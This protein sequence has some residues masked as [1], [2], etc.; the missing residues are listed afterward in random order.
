MKKV[1]TVLFVIALLSGCSSSNHYSY[2]SEGDTV[3]FSGPNN[4]TYTKNDLYKSL[5]VAAKDAI[6]SD[7][8]DNIALELDG[9]DLEA[10]E[11]DADELIETYK[12]LGYEA[13]IISSYGS[14][15]AYRKSYVSSMLLSELSK[16][17][18]RQ[19]YDTLSVDK[20]PVKMQVASFANMEDAQKCIDDTKIGSTF[21]MAAVNNN[22]ASAPVSNVYTDD[23]TSLAFEVKEYLNSTNATGLSGIITNTATTQGADG[24]TVETNTYYVLNVESRDPN[25]FKEDFIDLLAATTSTD[26]VKEHFLS[27]HDIKFFDQDLYELM[28]AEYEALK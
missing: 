5:K 12:S 28:S 25:E 13:Y 21:D 16:E 20:K 8:L 1:L 23:D 26:T 17:Y 27:T 19:N 24:N 15:E 3:L 11:A 6:S 14:V 9:I 7:I 10:I 18:V 4:V 2:P 22:A